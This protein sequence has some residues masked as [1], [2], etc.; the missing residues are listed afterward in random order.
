MLGV[1]AS[2]LS[3]K[4]IITGSSSGTGGMTSLQRERYGGNCGVT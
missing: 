3:C 1:V 2:A 4:G